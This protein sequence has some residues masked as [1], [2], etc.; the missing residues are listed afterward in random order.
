MTGNLFKIFLG[1]IFFGVVF[2]SVIMIFALKKI[3][4]SEPY[5]YAIEYIESNEEVLKYTGGIEGYGFFKSGKTLAA[6]KGSY[7]IFTIPVNGKE[8]D[9]TVNIKVVQD[10]T[11]WVVDE[12]S[13]R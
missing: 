12:F 6:P 7:G 4:K 9:V 2:V 1:F 5:R 8:N 3:E 11:G 13:L 10:S